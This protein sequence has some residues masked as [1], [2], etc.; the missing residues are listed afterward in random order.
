MYNLH[1]NNTIWA[2]P[3]IFPLHTDKRSCYSRQSSKL[4]WIF[5]WGW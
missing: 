2:W 5:F 4:W 1:Q 3:W